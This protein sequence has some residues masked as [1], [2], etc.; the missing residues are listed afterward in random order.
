MRKVRINVT[1]A[2]GALAAADVTLGVLVPAS[3]NPYRIMSAQL[4]WALVDLGNSADDGQVFGI[5][6][7]DYTAPEVEACLE[8]T[9]AIDIGDMIAQEVSNRLVREVGTMAG[10]AGTGAA[11]DF[12]DGAP[13][14]TKLNWKVGIGDTVSL[15]IRNASSTVWTTGGSL[16]ASG[17]IWVKDGL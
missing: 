3:T 4:A 15:W 13:V 10:T 6:H 17:I 2:V 9:T 1:F 14:K 7:G 16:T 12:N 8:S 5:S 11:L